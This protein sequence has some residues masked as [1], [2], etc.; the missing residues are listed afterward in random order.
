MLGSETQFLPVTGEVDRKEMSA[1]W[2]CPGSPRR[3]RGHGSHCLGLSS[4]SGAEQ[5]QE[6]DIGEC[7]GLPASPTTYSFFIVVKYA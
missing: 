3:G 5:R 4:R 7:L 2:K 1:A 6:V